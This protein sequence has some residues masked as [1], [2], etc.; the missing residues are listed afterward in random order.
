MKYL[1]SCSLVAIVVAA[2]A[3]SGCRITTHKGQDANGEN[4]DVD[5]RTPL[6]SISVHKGA[7]DASDTGLSLYPGAQVKMDE[8][9][10]DGA[11][12]N[13][14]SSLFGGLKVVAVKFKSDDP[15]EKVLSFY[16]KDMGRY[17]NVIDCTGSFSMDF[18][19]GSRHGDDEV[20]CK[21]EGSS[22][23]EYKEQLKVGTQNN[24]RIVAIRPSGAGSEF[25]LVYVRVR[26]EKATL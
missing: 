12:V 26:D 13:M 20:S 16:R 18:H 6:G 23:H 2:L 11:N 4:K 9:G 24:Q 14:S 21:G 5:I 1:N 7:T 8:D 19:P 25:A 17:G 3:L 22:G 10:R 15:P